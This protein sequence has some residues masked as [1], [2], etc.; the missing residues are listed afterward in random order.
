MRIAIDI[1][2]IN[3]FGI[4]TYIWNLVR[5]LAVVD[6]NNEYFLIGSDRNYQELGPL[7]ASFKQ[8]LQPEGSS[9]WRDQFSLPLALR[10]LD[11]DIVHVT[12]HESPIAVPSKLVVTIHDCVHV[13]FPPED[14]SRF[15]N[16]RKYVH[17]R[18]VVNR[19]N[20]VIAVSNS[21]K[22]D[23]IS[24]FNLAPSKVSVIHNALDSRF[25]LG[26]DENPAQVLER[27]QL[28]DPF[29]LYSGRIRPHKNLHRLIEAFAVL[30][31]ELADSGPL[32][33]LK[34]IIIGDE[35][36]QHQYLRLTV[37]RSGVQQDVRFFGFVPYPTLRV[38]YQSAAM[39]AFPSLYEGFGLPPLEAMANRTAV[40]ASDTSSLPEVLEDAALLVNPENV[41]EIARGMKTILLDAAVRQRLIEK[42]AQ[43]VTKFSWQLAA[44]RVVETYQRV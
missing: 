20:Q 16:Y 37:V 10:K 6:T 27:Y 32:R 21:T 12:H 43:Q 5:N 23:L 2:K 17:T 41:F 30:K 38:F 1:R 36:S 40:L 18:R 31:S 8:F 24:L 9:M 15:Q 33:N 42:G 29:I 4:G 34:L 11:A 25:T 28:K 7:P 44:K 13:M 19:A 3:E 22:D 14:A 39:F 35:L 26:P